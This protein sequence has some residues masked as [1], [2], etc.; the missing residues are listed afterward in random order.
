MTLTEKLLNERQA[1]HGDYKEVARIA[2]EFRA[3]MRDSVGW[4]RMSDEQR[5][6]LDSMASKFGRLGS[7]DP[8]FRDH[9]DDVAGYAT[10]ASINCD[11]DTDTISR[12]IAS[13]VQKI[14]IGPLDTEGEERFPSIVTMPKVEKKKGF[15]SSNKDETDVETEGEVK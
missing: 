14:Q 12:D 3:I 10:L 13:V 7:G 8:H 4:E 5:E 1:T 2:Q 11:S 15:F 6:A 9:W